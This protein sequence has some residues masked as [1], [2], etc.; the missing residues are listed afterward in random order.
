MKSKNVSENGIFEKNMVMVLIEQP[1]I[2]RSKI[3]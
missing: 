3:A 2:G 1:E